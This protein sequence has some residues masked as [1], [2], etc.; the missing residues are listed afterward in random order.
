MSIQ[1]YERV[2]RDLCKLSNIQDSKSIIN[3]GPVAVSGVVFSLHPGTGPNEGDLLL[4][5]DF[6]EMS[7]GHEAEV[8]RSLLET[9]L[10]M[11]AANGPMYAVSPQSGRVIRQQRYALANMKVEALRDTLAL[12]AATANEWR[13]TQLLDNPPVKINGATASRVQR[14]LAG[15]EPQ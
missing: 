9:N 6:G 15:D 2:I 12:L 8:S 11:Y 5:C 13:K 14:R 7:K 10:L 1:L 3:G 4:Y